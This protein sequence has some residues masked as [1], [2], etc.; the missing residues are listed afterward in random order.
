MLRDALDHYLRPIAVLAG[1][2]EMIVSAEYSPDGQRILTAAPD[3]TARVWD[4][5]GK[6][7]TTLSHSA[8]GIASATFSPDGQRILT[9][10]FDAVR[11][12]DVSGK[13]LTTIRVGAARSPTRCSTRMGSAS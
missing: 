8:Q 13:L 12:W 6:L 9:T 1:H 2:T 7:L 10:S 4:A 11:V 3:G 5:N